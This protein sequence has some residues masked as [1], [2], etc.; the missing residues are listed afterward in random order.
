MQLQ[1][2]K[3]FTFPLGV[4]KLLLC[5]VHKLLYHDFLDTVFDI[6]VFDA[7]E[8]II[9]VLLEPAQIYQLL[10]ISLLLFDRLNRQPGLVLR[11]TPLIHQFQQLQV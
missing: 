11:G 7:R 2:F 6:L 5:F 4:R 1:L 8:W 9:S 10:L 3:V